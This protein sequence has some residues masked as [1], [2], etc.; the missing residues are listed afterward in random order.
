MLGKQQLLLYYIININ[1]LEL[2]KYFLYIF[3]SLNQDTFSKY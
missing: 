2:F 1:I 3:D